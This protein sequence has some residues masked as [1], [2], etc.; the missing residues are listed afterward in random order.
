MWSYQHPSIFSEYKV[1]SFTTW[2]PGSPQAM[3]SSGWRLNPLEQW[4]KLTHPPFLKKKSVY[5][6]CFVKVTECWPTHHDVTIFYLLNLFNFCLLKEKWYLKSN[7]ALIINPFL[8]DW[9][10]SPWKQPSVL[11]VNGNVTHFLFIFLAVTVIL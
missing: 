8:C 4:V 5:F 2:R 3:T 11:K 6:G 10:L 1:S 9:L 7:A